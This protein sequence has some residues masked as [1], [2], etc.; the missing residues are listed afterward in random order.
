MTIDT[1]LCA[2]IVVPYTHCYDNTVQAYDMSKLK[3][4]EFII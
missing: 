4:E 2:C 3:Y 1:V